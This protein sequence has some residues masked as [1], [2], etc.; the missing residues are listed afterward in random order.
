MRKW[1]VRLL[2]AALL[3][4]LLTGCRA[5]PAEAESDPLRTYA[6]EQGWHAEMFAW[7]EFTD[8]AQIDALTPG[9]DTPEAFVSG[10]RSRVDVLQTLTDGTTLY[11]LL[12]M[13]SQTWGRYARCRAAFE[14]DGADVLCESTAVGG[15]EPLF[16]CRFVGRPG[17]IRTGRVTLTVTPHL[18]DWSDG[19]LKL[20]W[21]LQAGSVASRLVYAPG[22]SFGGAQADAFAVAVTPLGVYFAATAERPLLPETP[23]LT[24]TM[25]DNS[26]RRFDAD[27]AEI[28]LEAVQSRMGIRSDLRFYLPGFPN[29]G[30]AKSV[31]VCGTTVRLDG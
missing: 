28:E 30:N 21:K 3:A 27:T 25:R 15:E 1:N 5:T 8:R 6:L 26:W 10:N 29:L 24:V 9:L 2:A 4:L 16:L 12:R 19:E 31:T 11:I 14:A 20:T 23:E 18:G 17:G 22:A 7:F 13:E